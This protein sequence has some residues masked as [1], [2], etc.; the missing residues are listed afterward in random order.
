MKKPHLI[1]SISIAIFMLWSCNFDSEDKK[2]TSEEVTIKI[3]NKGPETIRDI[4]I[5]MVAASND[6]VFVD[7]FAGNEN[8]STY[9]FHK[10]IPQEGKDYPISMGDFEVSFTHKSYKNDIFIASPDSATIITIS[11]STI[12]FNTFSGN[13]TLPLAYTFHIDTNKIT[14]F[15]PLKVGYIWTYECKKSSYSSYYKTFEI[16]KIDTINDSVSIFFKGDST[17]YTSKSNGTFSQLSDAPFHPLVSD[18]LIR[19]K[20]NNYDDYWEKVDTGAFAGLWEKSE[21]FVSQSPQ[22]HSK[23][24]DWIQNVGLTYHKEVIESGKSRDSVV[25]K[26]VY[27]KGIIEFGEPVE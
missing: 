18:T 26:L 19:P 27:Y 14:T 16:E 15:A 5:S 7:S 11:D 17:P 20:N 23:S 13:D 22:Y 8:S 12:I 21:S 4:E 1:L 24:N 10:P 6:T 3:E 9:T 25:Q 2:E